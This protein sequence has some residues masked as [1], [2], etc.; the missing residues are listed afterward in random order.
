MNQGGTANWLEALVNGLRIHGDEVF[1]CAGFVESNEIED[2]IFQSLNGYR[3]RSLKRNSNIT[4][5]L[6]SILEIRRLIKKIE[7][8]ILNTH[9]GK[10]GFLGRIAALGL[11]VQV[12]H[13]Y[14]GHLLYGYFGPL[15]TKLIILCEKLMNRLTDHFIAV[16]LKVKDELIGSGIGDESRFTVIYPAIEKPERYQNFGKKPHQINKKITVGW[17]GRLERIKNPEMVMQAARF[18]PNI[19]F[20]IGGSGTLESELCKF[21]GSN[22]IL[23]GWVSSE[24]FWKECDLALLTS[25]NEGIPTSLI[26]A[27]FAKLPI[28]ATN[29]G[30]VTEVF[31]NKYGGFLIENEIDLFKAI[32]FFIESPE[33]IEL[34]GEANFN[35][36]SNKFSVERF[37]DAHLLIYSE[38]MKRN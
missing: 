15:K 16:G 38:L 7:P 21:N 14:H 29:V 18:F 20:K 12:V 27:S 10:A 22:L 8:D 23:E 33:K 24:K 17:L 6:K 32:S 34:F 9:T 2:N 5:N 25:R 37:L 3:I 13:T 30:S 36:A 28:I 35:Y 4:A 11:N 19:N 31:D 1:L 26:E